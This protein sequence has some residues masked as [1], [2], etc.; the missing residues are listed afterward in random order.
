MPPRTVGHH[1]SRGIPVLVPGNGRSAVVRGRAPREHH[2]SVAR[3]RRQR[4]WRARRPQG[5]GQHSARCAFALAVSCPH[6]EG[7]LLTVPQ[8]GN[9]HLE[10]QSGGV[11]P[12]TVGHHASGGISVLVPGNGRS[13]IVRGRTPGEHHLSVARSGG[14]GC[15]C[16]RPPN[17]RGCGIACLAFALAVS[18]PHLEGVLL[19]VAQ[20]LNRP[21]EHQSGRAP[22]RFG[23]DGGSGR[24]SVLVAGNGRSAIVCGRTPGEQHLSVARRCRQ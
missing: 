10:D 16:S 1:A 14:Q 13:A 21:L 11:P 15:R 6:L 12:R 8:S 18:C 22:Q 7:V 17:R 23:G 20:S 2:P 19:T 9:R 24:I 4:R 3:R 5:H